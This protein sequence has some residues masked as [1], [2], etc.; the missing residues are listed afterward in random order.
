MILLDFLLI[1]PGLGTPVTSI[2]PRLP[3][4]PEALGKADTDMMNDSLGKVKAGLEIRDL[5][6]RAIFLPSL[7]LVHTFSLRTRVV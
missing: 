3:G 7:I 1:F 2:P 5:D 6:P 4:R